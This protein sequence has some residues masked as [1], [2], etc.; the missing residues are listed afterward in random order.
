MRSIRIVAAAVLA[1]ATFSAVA[2]GSDVRSVL[3]EFGLIGT[4]SSDCGK[5]ISQPRAGRLVFATSADGGVT[6]TTQDNKDEVLV[7]TVYEIA[8]AAIVDGDKISTALHPVKVTKS[9][10]SAAS[11][12]DYDN[13]RLVFQKAGERIELVRIQFEGLPE[14]ERAS[15]FEKCPS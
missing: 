6:A 1:S 8:E 14:I 2:F 10:G 3:T 15:F 7:T 13:L 5:E 4:W 9:D 12:H 11:Q